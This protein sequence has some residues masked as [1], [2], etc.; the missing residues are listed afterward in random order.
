M[1]RGAPVLVLA[2][3]APVF[4]AV[5]AT[6]LA[7]AQVNLPPPPPPPMGQGADLPPL[8]P[9]PPPPQPPPP[10]RTSPPP[11]ASPAPPPPRYA[12]RETPPP[13]PPYRARLAR[14]EEVVVV[15]EEPESHP[16]AIT[17]DPLPLFWGRLSANV[18]LLLAP[19]HAL[20]VSPNVLVF[21]EDRGGSG[22]LVSSGFGFASPTSNGFG[23][24]AGYH[25]WPRGFRS[26]R[27]TYLGPSLLLGSTTDATVGDA[28]HAQT[29]WGFAFDVGRQEVFSGGFT[30]G[31]GLGLGLVRMADV[32]RVFPRLLIQV[33]WSF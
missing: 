32:V 1:R 3:L 28:S 15:I 8:P 14:R 30:L 26:L 16:L 20:V 27:G 22:A 11:P 13:P 12:P 4:L 9:T 21:N 19:H 7:R 29:Y 23:V 5:G 18:E 31:A 2:V 33:G 10:P 17:L 25:Y 6:G 24:E